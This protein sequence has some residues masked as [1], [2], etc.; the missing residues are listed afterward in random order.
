MKT[1]KLR[2]RE[3]IANLKYNQVQLTTPKM[4]ISGQLIP[5][6]H[7]YMPSVVEQ[8]EP[9]GW[10]LSDDVTWLNTMF[11]TETLNWYGRKVAVFITDSFLEYKSAREL[12]PTATMRKF[13]QQFGI[14][15]H[16]S[17][18]VDSTIFMAVE[19]LD[20]IYASLDWDSTYS[21]LD[22]SGYDDDDKL[23]PHLE[24]RWGFLEDDKDDS[25]EFIEW[26]MLNKLQT[27]LR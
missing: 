9:R 24:D 7:K 23:L 22:L 25:G 2:F 4:N 11:I 16:V 19:N 3:L 12:Y 20:D 26:N 13:W 10:D 27:G 6:M 5:W 1:V 17:V 18:L 21:F 8:L 14:E 15:A